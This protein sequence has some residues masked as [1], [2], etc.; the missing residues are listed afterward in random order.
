MKRYYLVLVLIALF[1]S[2]K[3]DEEIVTG[4]DLFLGS[5]T[6]IR[7]TMIVANGEFIEFSEIPITKTIEGTTV[8]NGL[9]LGKGTDMEF[10]ASV[11]GSIFL[12]PGHSKHFVLENSGVEINFSITGQGL[13]NKENKLTI[14]YGSYEKIDKTEYKLTISESLTKVEE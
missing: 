10:N 2:C 14:T 9:I 13:W 6:G 5:Y 4:P 11:D 1:I 8:P 7:T 12:I 3:E